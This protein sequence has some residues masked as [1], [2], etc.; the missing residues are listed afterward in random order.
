L[1]AAWPLETSEIAVPLK[2]QASFIVWCDADDGRILQR[3]N[4][5]KGERVIDAIGDEQGW[6]VQTSQ[7]LI[8]FRPSGERQ[9][10]ATADKQ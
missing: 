6:L 4:L 8:A 3:L 10:V 5:P 9:D 2:Q 7:N 1:V